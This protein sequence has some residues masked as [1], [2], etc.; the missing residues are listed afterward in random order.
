MFQYLEDTSGIWA[1]VGYLFR[2]SSAAVVP[3]LRADT[4]HAAGFAR[5]RE[6]PAK[7]IRSSSEMRLPFGDA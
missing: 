7:N 6:L 2:T 4:M 5:I 3:A 1:M